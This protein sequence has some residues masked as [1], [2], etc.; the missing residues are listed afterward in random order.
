MTND[1][2]NKSEELR[3]QPPK[4]ISI[5]LGS[6]SAEEYFLV[7]K[8]KKSNFLFQMIG[9]HNSCTVLRLF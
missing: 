5:L 2:E 1:T 9:T 3:R 7:D 8:N 4:T 6:G